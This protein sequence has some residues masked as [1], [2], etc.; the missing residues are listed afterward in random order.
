MLTTKAAKTAVATC[1]AGRRKLAIGFRRARGART[2]R[3]R[4]HLKISSA[5]SDSLDL[6]VDGGVAGAGAFHDCPTAPPTEH[7]SVACTLGTSGGVGSAHGS[8]GSGV[9]GEAARD[10]GSSPNL[11]RRPAPLAILAPEAQNV[12]LE[13]SLELVRCRSRRL[14]HGLVAC[15]V[16]K[17]PV[18]YAELACCEYASTVSAC[19]R[20]VRSLGTI[21]VSTVGAVRGFKRLL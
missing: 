1:V 10:L 15:A 11:A 17:Q 8:A 2:T 7:H 14:V 21:N 6:H 9:G 5:P 16:L 18:V 12:H 19:R 4:C 13:T 20:C 3:P